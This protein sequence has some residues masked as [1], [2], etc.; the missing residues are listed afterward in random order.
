[1]A[2][3]GNT[4]GDNYSRGGAYSGSGYGVDGNGIDGYAGAGAGDGY[5]PR[6][7]DYV[8]EEA[9]EAL[10]PLKKR[11]SIDLHVTPPTPTLTPSHPPSN[12]HPLASFHPPSP[13]L[14]PAL[15][16]SFLPAP[17]PRPRPHLRFGALVSRRPM[18]VISR[19]RCPSP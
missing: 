10:S 2:P 11:P 8:Q 3:V 7:G 14:S 12:T 4:R 18:A 9:L 5:D 16:P 17:R 6:G 15:S 1:M 19:A 13:T